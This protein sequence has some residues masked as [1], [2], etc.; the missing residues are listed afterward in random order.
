MISKIKRGLGIILSIM[1]MLSIIPNNFVRVEATTGTTYYLDSINGD[2]NSSGT[3]ENSAWKNLSKI[4]DMV[5]EAGDKILLKSGS[6]WNNQQLK[7]NGSGSEGQPVIVDKYGEGNDPIINVNGEE[8]YGLYLLNGEYWEIGN[9]EITNK[10]TEEKRGRTGVMIEAQNIG[11][12]NHIYLKNLNVHDVNGDSFKK[13][14]NNGGIFFVVNDDTKVENPTISKFN[15]ILVEGCTV[16]DVNRS[17]ISVGG[18]PWDYKFNGHGGYFP[19]ELIDTTTH[20]NVLIRNNYVEASGGDAIVLE[21]CNKPLVEYNIA[22][23]C[24]TTSGANSQYSA[25]IWPWRCVDAVFQFNE[26]YGTKYNGDGMAYD[27]DYGLRTVYQ[28]NYSH[29]NEGG[30]MLM[31]QDES[32]DS[33]VRYNISQNDRDGA[34]SISGKAS[35]Q[36]YNNV[37]YIGKGVDAKPFRYDSGTGDISINNNAFYNEGVAIR[38]N[39]LKASQYSNNS[40]YG[41]YG[42]EGQ[43]G[44]IEITGAEQVIGEVGKGLNEYL[45]KEFEAVYCGLGSKEDFE[46]KD[47]IGKVALLDRGVLTF[48]DKAKNAREAGAS[49]IIL[50]N[51]QDGVIPNSGV[52]NYVSMIGITRELGLKVKESLSIGDS[53]KV[54]IR[55]DENSNPNLLDTNSITTDP[56]FV[57]PGTGANGIDSVNGYMLQDNS[58]LINAGENIENNGGRDYF[59]NELNDG[60]T[61]IGAFESKNGAKI[62]VSKINNLKAEVLV[63]TVNLSW[64]KPSDEYGLVEYVI[65]KDGKELATLS[66]ETTSYAATELRKNTLYGFK[67]VA[68]YSNGEKSKPVSVNLR[69]KK[70]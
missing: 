33:I 50:M 38:G 64:E 23:G 8:D 67:V 55:K 49:F 69:T 54:I 19:Q 56:M 5:F 53:T 20:T 58:P 51:N 18:S 62:V 44:D 36:I 15:D 6:I 22:N 27:C 52:G 40:Y 26:V 63:D 3:N 65:Y 1:M 30:F 7:L 11:V 16:K 25:G 31:C 17:G 21:Y 45:D 61:D 37:I 41:Y 57:A 29:D 47:L 43:I 24:N 2:D 4:K 28:Y 10:G 34:L 66:K 39:W 59:G 35:G 60:I 70:A 68:K 42:F 14:M 48:G 12:L 46:G 13:D 9:L 32:L